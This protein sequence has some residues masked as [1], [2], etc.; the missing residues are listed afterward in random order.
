MVAEAVVEAVVKVSTSIFFNYFA[1]VSHDTRQQRKAGNTTATSLNLTQMQSTKQYRTWN[2]SAVEDQYI[3][4]PPYPSPQHYQG[5]L[6]YHVSITT[7]S[8]SKSP[9]LTVLMILLFLS[10]AHP[11]CYHLV[12]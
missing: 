10:I 4:S 6:Y 5:F 11:D 2:A 8:V 7:A 3:S 12:P 1:A 9:F